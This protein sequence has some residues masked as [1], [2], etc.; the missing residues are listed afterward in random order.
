M[1]PTIA[2]LMGG[3]AGGLVG[4]LGTAWAYA[5]GYLKLEKNER[6]LAKVRL[7]DDIIAS[8]FALDAAYPVSETDAHFFNRTMSRIPY[9]FSGDKKVMDA[10]DKFM[11]SPNETDRLI[12]LIRSTTDS[13]EIKG[14]L[15]PRYVSGVYSIRPRD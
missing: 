14:G 3:V 8:R 15:D 2:G 6:R 10:Y 5:H 7:V 12:D 1:D 13:A 11:A 9:I 4:A